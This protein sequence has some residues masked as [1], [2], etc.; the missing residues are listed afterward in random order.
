MTIGWR[1]K[2]RKP[3]PRTAVTRWDPGTWSC[4]VCGDERPDEKVSVH[5][6]RREIGGVTITQNV[7]YCNDRPDCVTGAPGISFFGN[8]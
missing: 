1:R 7:R 5:Q 8:Q 2:P 6:T 4:H 3:E